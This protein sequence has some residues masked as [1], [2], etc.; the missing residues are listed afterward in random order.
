VIRGGERGCSTAKDKYVQNL[1]YTR[2]ERLQKA[3]SRHASFAS[4][5]EEPRS[6][7]HTF[8]CLKR[9]F[10]PAHGIKVPLSGSLQ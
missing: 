3:A 5:A 7:T 9:K 4:S 2:A 6:L 8:F 10:L 1:N